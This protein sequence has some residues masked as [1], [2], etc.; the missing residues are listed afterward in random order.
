MTISW[1]KKNL[2][3]SGIEKRKMPLNEHR[4]G[5]LSKSRPAV[6]DSSILYPSAI[7]DHTKGVAIIT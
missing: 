2:A 4:E 3:N 7:L 1:P 6:E 5:L